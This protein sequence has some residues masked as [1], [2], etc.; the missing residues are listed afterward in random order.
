MNKMHWLQLQFSKLD[1]NRLIHSLKTAIAFL[2]G[3]FLVRVFDF[4]MQGQWV[5]ISILVVMCAQSRVGAIIQK[6]YMR[7]LGTILGAVI[8]ALTLC[9]AYPSVIWTTLILCLTTALFSY[10]AASPGYLS[11]A[12]PLGAVTAVIILIGL[13]PSYSSL[14]NRFFEISLGIAIALLVSRFIW[15][16]HSRTQLR[17]IVTTTLQDLKKILEQL[18]LFTSTEV[19]KDYE[20][21][22]DKVISRF[23]S[24]AQL[25]D[26]VM[27]ESFGHST[28]AQVF[29][30]ILRAEREILRCS[31]LIK[32]ALM[33]FSEAVH[34]N[35]NEQA[36][37]KQFYSLSYQLFQLLIELLNNKTSHCT[38]E[39]DRIDWEKSLRCA[40]NSVITSPA[41][42]LALD[43]FLFA[44]EN[45]LDQLKIMN[46]LIKKIYIVDDK[47]L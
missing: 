24:Q 5:L 34:V 36:A 4:P 11:E 13:N 12:G 19:E 43:L 41:D 7:F 44:A 37:V 26:E 32:N 14:L 17:Y 2:I 45:L 25:L 30:E 1:N 35:F 6:S 28:L 3:M 22:E 8:A 42:Q 9:L 38:I 27:R 18:M 10:I 46:S 16:L 20:I 47:L 21:Y 39:L 15:P 31:S 29:K 33:S 40:L 23:T